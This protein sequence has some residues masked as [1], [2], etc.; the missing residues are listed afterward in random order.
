VLVSIGSQVDGRPVFT[1]SGGIGS[2]LDAVLVALQEGDNDLQSV[3]EE[4]FFRR[5]TFEFHRIRDLYAWLESLDAHCRKRLQSI[6]LHLDNYNGQ[7]RLAQRAF[8]LLGRSLELWEVKIVITDSLICVIRLWIG[9]LF[10]I[11]EG[12]RLQD[13]Q[14]R[15]G[16]FELQVSHACSD[17]QAQRA[18]TAEKYLRFFMYQRR[19]RGRP[20]YSEEHAFTRRRVFAGLYHHKIPRNLYYTG[21]TVC[22]WMRELGMNPSGSFAQRF[23]AVANGQLPSITGVQ[24]HHRRRRDLPLPN[25]R[26]YDT[27]EYA[28]DFFRNCV[29]TQ[30]P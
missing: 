3:V 4:E 20:S 16:N 2:Q 30:S 21:S 13:H 11:L 14:G 22:R 10:G 25:D 29:G 9:G 7:E 18:M 17:R 24:S 5:T 26:I 27:M 15:C 6:V 23:E 28:G 12:Y 19:P 1:Y 8:I